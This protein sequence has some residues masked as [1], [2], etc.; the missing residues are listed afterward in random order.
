VVQSWRGQESLAAA[1]KQGYRG[2]LSYGYYL[3]LI[4][5]AARHYAVDPMSGGAAFLTP[6]E[7]QRILGGEACMWSEHITLET[8]D[9]RVWPRLAAIAERFWS[10]QNV[11]DPKSMYQRMDEISWRLGWLGLTHESSYVPMLRRLAG[12]EDIAALR[13]LADVVEPTKDYTRSEVFPQPPVRITPL[14]RLADAVRPESSDA[15]KV[16]ELVNTYLQNV[17]HK[18][19][20]EEQIR[21]YLT[22]WRQNDADLQP[23][24]DQ[25]FLLAEDKPLSEDLSA[26][27]AAGLQALDALD[28]SQSLS[29]AWRTEQLAVVARSNTPRANLLL[30]VAPPIQKLIDAAA[31]R[32]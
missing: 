8:I 32:H 17:Q 22:A 20:A 12:R 4:W 9:S 27:G 29:D 19:A 21:F 16:S 14:N 28:N 25:S 3:D 26:L 24:L 7:Q 1:A 2:L 15:R 5:P 11:T 30:M 10:P 13:V 23:L 31:P 6:E 18:S